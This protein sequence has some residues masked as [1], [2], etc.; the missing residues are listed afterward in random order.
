MARV[1]VE[2]TSRLMLK[3]FGLVADREDLSAK[4]I[5]GGLGATL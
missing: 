2:P 1:S 3:P 4:L 5:E